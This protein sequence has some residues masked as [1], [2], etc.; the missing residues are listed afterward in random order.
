MRYIRI[1]SAFILTIFT[2]AVLNAEAPSLES[3]K[4]PQ[5][6]AEEV[7]S[8]TPTPSVQAMESVPMVTS[9]KDVDRMTDIFLRGGFCVIT[10]VLFLAGFMAVK[11]NGGT[12]V[13]QTES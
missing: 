13:H 10:A 6:N 2:S 8:N 7:H 3:T 1:K 4:P 11:S 9:K 12:R 5:P